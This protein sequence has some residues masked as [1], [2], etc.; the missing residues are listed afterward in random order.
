[1]NELVQVIVEPTPNPNSLKFSWGKTVV[2]DGPFDFP[3]ARKA[4][5]S[6]LAT[7]IFRNNG[8]LGV[9]VGREFVTVTKHEGVS[10]ER[11]ETKVIETLRDHVVSGDP[12]VDDD[13][14]E[15][16]EED[17]GVISSKIREIL[18][19][20]IRPAVAMDGGDIIF[21]G[22]DDGIVRLRL[23]GSCSGCPSSTATLKM[24][25]EGRLK[26]A[27]PEVVEVVAVS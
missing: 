1:M 12:M 22:Y 18:D 25:I 10:W 13:I 20:D 27:I 9:F 8:V 11:L 2:D 17:H 4:E 14:K 6:P 15:G 16:V 21:M 19:R 26:Q 23:Q 5:K 3:D 24:G 7:K